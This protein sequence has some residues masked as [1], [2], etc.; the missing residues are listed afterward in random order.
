MDPPSCSMCGKPLPPRKSRY[1]SP[2]CSNRAGWVAKYGLTPEDYRT[3]LGN[4][5]CF[6][7]DRKMRKVNV[8]HSHQTGLVRGLVCGTCNKR[9][10]TNITTPLQ[11]FRLLQYLVDNPATMLDGKSRSVGATISSRDKVQRRRQHRERY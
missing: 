6:I 5:R 8:D 2:K 11:A 9:V 4:G 3:L 10:L 1:C 7:C